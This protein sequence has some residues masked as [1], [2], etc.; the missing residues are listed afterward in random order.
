MKRMKKMRGK[1]IDPFGRTAHRQLERELIDEYRSTIEGLLG[2]LSAEN[3]DT[4]VEVAELPDMIRGY[5]EIKERNV[6]AYRERLAEL[7][8]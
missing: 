6:E 2:G 8:G 1:A 4:A 3:F 5:E 7:L